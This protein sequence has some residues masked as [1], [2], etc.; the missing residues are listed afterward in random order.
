MDAY[1]YVL[2]DA[3]VYN[4]RDRDWAWR[5]VPA[6]AACILSVC[7]PFSRYISQLDLWISPIIVR[8]RSSGPDWAGL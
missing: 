7:R 5:T 3:F 1:D 2:R 6:G 8:N 4:L